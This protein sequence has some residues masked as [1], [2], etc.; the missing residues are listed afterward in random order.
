MYTYQIYRL[1]SLV[2]KAILAQEISWHDSRTT[3]GLA[4][5]VSEYKKVINQ[6]QEIHLFQS[7]YV[8]ET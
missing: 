5:R 2:V 1:R 8:I 4:V 3:D 7:V 6:N